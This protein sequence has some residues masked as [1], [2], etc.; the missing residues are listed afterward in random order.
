MAP[1]QGLFLLCCGPYALRTPT[2]PRERAG[3]PF[4]FRP[5]VLPSDNARQWIMDS[6]L[7]GLN[8][9]TPELGVEKEGRKEKREGSDHHLARKLD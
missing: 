5:L 4:L 1:K 6:A 9:Q 7:L 2:V 8:S 3:F